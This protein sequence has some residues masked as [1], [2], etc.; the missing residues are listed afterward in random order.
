V[1]TLDCHLD[2]NMLPYRE[3]LDDDDDDDDDDVGQ[4]NRA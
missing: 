4:F 1:H 3:L 2:W